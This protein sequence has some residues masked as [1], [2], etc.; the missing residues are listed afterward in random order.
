MGGAGPAFDG[1]VIEVRRVMEMADLPP[2]VQ[3]AVG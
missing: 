1:D 2:D 3:A